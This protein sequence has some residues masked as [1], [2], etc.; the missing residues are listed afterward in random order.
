MSSASDLPPPVPATPVSPQPRKWAAVFAVRRPDPD[1]LVLVR[2]RKP[3]SLAARSLRG[4]LALWG[5]LGTLI[6]LGV[7]NVAM[8]LA[9]TGFLAVSSFTSGSFGL[10]LFVTGVLIFFLDAF[11]LL[12]LAA[13]FSGRWITFD[14]R[15]GRVI[16]SRRRLGW[17]PEGEVVES[18]RLED[19][20]AVQL[21]YGGTVSVDVGPTTQQLEPYAPPPIMVERPWYEFNLVLRGPDQPRLTLACS[22]DWEWMRAVGPE[23]ATFL[24]V[25][26]VD[27]LYQG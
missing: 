25:P 14:R 2:G 18:R 9:M 16:V 22:T 11:V 19:I 20:V 21:V 7:F 1:V 6:L 4:R 12:A 13:A 17:G 10:A 26:L 5:C 27:Q 24:G 15:Q 8:L 23:V 3:L